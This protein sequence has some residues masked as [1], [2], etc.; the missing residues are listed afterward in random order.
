MVG[1]LDSAGPAIHVQ[2]RPIWDGLIRLK[3]KGVKIRVVTE[4]MSEN[5]AYCK[6]LLEVCEIR[7]LDGVRTNFGIADGKEALL[8]G[9]S[10]ETNP[11]SQA[12][13][14]TVRGIVEAQEYLFENLWKNAIP[15]QYKITEIEEGIKPTFIETLRDS[16]EIQKLVFDIVAL[17]KEE[18]LILLIQHTT[19]GNVFLIKE[20]VKK[21]IE[22]LKNAVIEGGVRIRILTSIDVCKQIDEL[23]GIQKAMIMLKETERQKEHM[24]VDR[25][26]VGIGKQGKFEIH[27]V[28]DIKKQQQHL[29]TKVS[30]LIVDSKVSLLEEPNTNNKADN[31]P[32]N[33]LVLAT[34]SNSESTLLAYISIFETLWTQTEL[35]QKLHLH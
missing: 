24:E 4:I 7:H 25:G 20:N 21:I 9:V 8:H 1:S 15:A 32:N 30:I 19:I 13:L 3:E 26:S 18:I 10:Q 6:K 22:L 27:L 16:F 35:K 2:Y 34:Y 12:I 31:N 17:A 28:D 23:T 14:T 5:I 29:Q 33:D 11:L